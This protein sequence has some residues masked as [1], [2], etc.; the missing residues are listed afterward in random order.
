MPSE[1]VVKVLTTNTPSNL[2]KQVTYLGKVFGTEKAA[3]NWVRE[4]TSAVEIMEK[5]AQELKLHEKRVVVQMHQEEFIRWLGFDVVGVFSAE[6]LSP[7]RVIEFASLKPDLV[8]DN[9]HNPQGMGIAEVAGVP[10]VE[11][12]NFPEEADVDI[13]KLFKEN[14][15]KLAYFWETEE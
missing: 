14:W 4:F 6:E 9:Y 7:A 3:G 1:Q 5:Q 13:S 2:V 15:I 12:R 10:R 11:I 8:I